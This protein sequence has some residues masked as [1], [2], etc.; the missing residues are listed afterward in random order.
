[1]LRCF[2]LIGS[3]LLPDIEINPAPLPALRQKPLH[4][5]R[6]G[7]SG[8]R[9]PVAP[10]PESRL[11]PRPPVAQC[12]RPT[13][14][15]C[16]GREGVVTFFSVCSQRCSGLLRALWLFLPGLRGCCWPLP[17]R[18]AVGLRPPAERQGT[19]HQGPMAPDGPVGADL[20][21]RPAQ[22]LF[23][24]PIALLDPQPQPISSYR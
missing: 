9:P 11:Q 5:W 13:V 17:R 1:M 20:I 18:G 6:W 15:S 4:C 22:G 24:L 8:P 12:H 14:P 21:R 3:L 23:D 2:G 19:I 10:Q 16:C 7:Q